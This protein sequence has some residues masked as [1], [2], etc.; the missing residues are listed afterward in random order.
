M[1]IVILQREIVVREGKD[2]IDL[3]V[4]P[5]SG[6]RP[7]LTSQLKFYLLEVV[8][9]DVQVTDGED[10]L[11]RLEVRDLCYHQGEQRVRR[12][13]ERQSEEKISRTLV[14]LA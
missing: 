3:R 7:R 12:Y 9:V 6:L 4:E 13:V 10:E 11:T 2:V 5:H 1:W 8:A 14:E